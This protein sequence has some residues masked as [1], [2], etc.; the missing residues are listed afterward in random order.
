MLG[1]VITFV[2]FILAIYW[3]TLVKQ[4]RRF[5]KG[6]ESMSI[7][8]FV[9]YCVLSLLVL[10]FVLSVIFSVIPEFL[11]RPYKHQFGHSPEIMFG[12]V[13]LIVISI[14]AYQCY[15]Y[16]KITKQ[17]NGSTKSNYTLSNHLSQIKQKI[18]SDQR[19]YSSS[20][21]LK[22]TISDEDVLFCKY[23]GKGIDKEMIYC[24]FCGKKLQIVCES[25]SPLYN[26]NN[27]EKTEEGT[28]YNI[29]VKEQQNSIQYDQEDIEVGSNERNDKPYTI[30]SHPK[31]E[32]ISTKVDKKIYIGFILVAII[33]I[34]IYII[35]MQSGTTPN[36]G[37]SHADDKDST[38]EIVDT[39]FV[40]YIVNYDFNSILGKCKYTGSIID[41][42]P[43]DTEGEAIFSD[44][45]YYKGPFENG[46]LSGEN[47]FFRYPN[48]DEFK[49]VFKDNAFYDGTYTI[50]E[51]GSYF[52]GT[53]KNG[54]PDKGTWYDKNG[55]VI[56]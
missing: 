8:R 9:I 36:S 1:A 37:L 21:S 6:G 56:E 31:E 22:S 11:P 25:P 17:N 40:D 47:A 42:V 38:K 44:G 13:F 39:V 27:N 35:N 2:D 24:P 14:I 15:K 34:I 49:G 52:N 19:D 30:I 7:S 10:G 33:L 43:Y 29:I 45:R 55:N 48:G 3:L 50:E 46:N 12:I 18:Q 20:D 32:T 26:Q 16:V 41:G 5:C 28:G 23:C 4:F 51:D 54:Q 53:F